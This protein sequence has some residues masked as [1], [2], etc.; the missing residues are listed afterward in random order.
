MEAGALPQ[1]YSALHSL[2]SNFHMV[3]LNGFRVC[4]RIVDSW[5]WCFNNIF[6][7][8]TLGTLFFLCFVLFKFVRIL[9]WMC[10]YTFYCINFL[11]HCFR[12]RDNTYTTNSLQSR[13][14]ILNAIHQ[15]EIDE[16]CFLHFHNS[17]LPNMKILW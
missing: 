14:R 6:Y 9:E 11:K 5:V 10:T 15:M 3:L 2:A 7:F 17:L 4:D 1:S 8:L 16:L 13:Q 12:F